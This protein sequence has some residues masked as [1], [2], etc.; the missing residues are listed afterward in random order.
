MFPNQAASSSSN[1]W[2][3]MKSFAS[4]RSLGRSF[5]VVGWLFVASRATSNPW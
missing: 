4:G 1:A 2:S 3:L 5:L